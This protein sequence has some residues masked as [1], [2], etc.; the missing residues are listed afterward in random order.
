MLFV[1]VW[2]RGTLP[3]LRYDQFMRFGWK[4]LIPISLVWIVLVAVLRVGRR[5]RLVPRPGVLVV[6]RSSSSSG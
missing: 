3:R 6:A 2:L 5:E 1:F 4:W